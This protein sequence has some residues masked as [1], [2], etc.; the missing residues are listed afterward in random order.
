MRVIVKVI[1]M[2][3]KPNKE[4]AQVISFFKEVC[5]KQKKVQFKML[6]SELV[7]PQKCYKNA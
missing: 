3:K 5:T 2:I 4:L 7:S 6:K 1:A